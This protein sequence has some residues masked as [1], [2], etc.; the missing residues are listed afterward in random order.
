MKTRLA[1]LLLVALTPSAPAALF[2]QTF[3]TD[4]PIIRRIWEEGD[5]R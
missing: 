5:S 4:D 3:P 1:L 2:A